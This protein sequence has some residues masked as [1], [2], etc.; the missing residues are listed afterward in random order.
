MN[1]ETQSD[2]APETNETVEQCLDRLLAMHP[3]MRD[4][5]YRQLIIY[6]CTKE[7]I[8][9]G[10]IAEEAR[11]RIGRPPGRVVDNPNES[12]AERLD[13]AENDAVKSLARE[14]AAKHLSA[15]DIMEIVNF[16]LKRE[17]AQ[18]LA[19]VVSLPNVSFRVLADRL[20]RFCALPLGE[21]HLDPSDLFGVRVNLARHFINDDLTF[22]GLAKKFVRIR[23]YEDITRRTIGSESRMGKIGGKAGGMFIAHRI[24]DDAALD[25]GPDLPIAIPDS[26]FVR[27]DVTEQFLE[28]NGLRAYHSQKYKNI[29]DIRNE[30]PLI[31]GVFRN[32]PFPVEIVQQLR[33]LIEQ[34]EETPLIVRSSSLLEDRCSS[35][36]SGKYASIFIPNQGKV[37]VR[38]RALLG[39]IG[40]VYASTL[41]PDPILYRRR[42]NL[43]DYDEEMGVLIQ[44]VVGRKMGKYFLPAFAGVALSRNEYRW[45]PRIKR[46]DGFLR[47]VLGL[48]TRAVDR[49]GADFARMVA[50]GAPTLRPD[51]TPLEIIRHSQKTIDVINLEENRFDSVTLPTLLAQ[52]EPFPMLDKFVSVRREHELYTPAGRMLDA[53]PEDM[54]ITFDKLLKET[55]FASRVQQMLQELE[56]SMGHPV[57][58]EFA[59]DGEKFYIL[60]CRGQHQAAPS[61][62]V[63]IPENLPV[64]KIVF[65][66]NRYVRTAMIRNIQYIV[67]VSSD[68]YH[69][70][71]SNDRRL[72]I[73]RV[74]GRVNQALAGKKFILVGPGRWGSNDVLL[75]IRVSYADINNAR[76]LI[77]VARERSGYVPEVSFGTHFFQDLVEDNIAYLPLY[78]DQDGNGFN[79]DLFLNTQNALAEIVPKD[80]SFSDEVRIIHVPDVADGC[81]LQIAMD[82]EQE[83]A[84]AYIG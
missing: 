30:Y 28:L 66:A 67:Y 73:A 52:G 80:A 53:A 42:H 29:E 3:T 78:P 1:P 75:G 40:E 61:E 81:R 20:E 76:M 19:D 84:V 38:L 79:S 5:I 39:A 18:N 44:K 37:E 68:A 69:S 55:P 57:D 8:T 43:I 56:Q 13:E 27:S 6:L 47:L 36:F 50:L 22:L 26:Y 11:K 54:C 51:A 35:A 33:S 74:I 12:G 65:T 7:L 9:M 32:S 48:G 58:V 31:R 60:Q 24:L 70:V 34:L 82:G 45:S 83:R 41:A 72:A 59:C 77:E 62:R 63:V 16:V 17:E 23:D 21:L 2:I 4:R 71:E 25:A 14:H 15:S 49:V 46:E 10:G 64:E